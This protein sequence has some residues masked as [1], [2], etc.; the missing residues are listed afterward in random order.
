MHLNGENNA[1]KPVIG[2][3]A[4]KTAPA[5][6]TMGHAGA[7]IGGAEETASAKMKIMKDYGIHVVESPADIGKSYV[8]CS[9]FKKMKLLKGKVSLVTG[10]SRGI[11]RSICLKF[12]ENRL[13]V[14]FTYN[15]SKEK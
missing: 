14:V 5:G 8:K 1:T 11:G 9:K 3:I 6:R 13:D 10:G 4:G 2:F 12:A 7:L 15:S